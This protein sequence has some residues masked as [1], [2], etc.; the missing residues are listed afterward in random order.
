MNYKKN[1][2]FILFVITLL[3]TLILVG[4]KTASRAKSTDALTGTQGLVMNFL[5][6]RPPD[7]IVAE[8]NEL[9]VP[10]TIEVRNKGAFP[11]PEASSSDRWTENDVIFVSGY[12][13]TLFLNWNVDDKDEDIPKALIARKALDGKSILNPEGGYD[14]VEFVGE[15]DVDS[16][17]IDRYKPGFLVTACYHYVT[18]ANPTVCI[19]NNPYSFT[20]EEKVCEVSDIALTSQK[21]F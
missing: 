5:P 6:N 7:K 11:S 1:S 4:C 2:K 18:R 13:P 15:L 19:D 8:A 21:K 20:S 17:K 16:L 3:L 9:E 10:I 14:T 12:D